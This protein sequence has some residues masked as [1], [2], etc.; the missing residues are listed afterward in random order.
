LPN[1]SSENA[2]QL[3]EGTTLNVYMY[4]AKRR[5]PQGPRDVTR[6]A[7]L[8]SPSVAYRHLQKLEAAGLLKRNS[9]GE[10]LLNQKAKVNGF[11]WVGRS[12][13]PRTM[14]YFYFFLGLLILEAVVLAIHWE[15]ENDVI[16]TYYAIGMSITGIAMAFFLLEA[17]TML[18]KLKVKDTA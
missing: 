3:L 5:N 18:R 8:S 11:H 12:L 16:K 9:Y 1:D 15:W 14:F 7:N 17:V 13:V 4:V 2:E 6:G 10:Y